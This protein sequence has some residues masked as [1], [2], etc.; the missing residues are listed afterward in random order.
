[1]RTTHLLSV[2][3]CGGRG[4]IALVLLLLLLW[5]HPTRSAHHTLGPVTCLHSW[6]THPRV[7]ALR[8]TPVLLLRCGR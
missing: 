7:H 2:L 3:P 8:V 4:G 6:A 5:R 1:M